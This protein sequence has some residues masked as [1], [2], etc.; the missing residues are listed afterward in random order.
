MAQDLLYDGQ[1]HA[2]PDQ[3]HGAG[4]AQEV[5]MSVEKY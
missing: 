4:M 3:F 5:R 1:G 2:G